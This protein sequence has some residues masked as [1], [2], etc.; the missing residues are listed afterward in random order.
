MSTNKK[1]DPKEALH[2]NKG[3]EKR[4][5]EEKWAKSPLLKY[6]LAENKAPLL[7]YMN[8]H[9]L[10]ALVDYIYVITNKSLYR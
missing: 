5:G 2:G 4:K 6:M 10:T 9:S 8:Y 3:K 1:I 7:K